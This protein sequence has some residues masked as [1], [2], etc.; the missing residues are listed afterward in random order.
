VRGEIAASADP[1]ERREEAAHD[2]P[3]DPGRH[4][5]SVGHPDRRAGASAHTANVSS[6]TF[7]LRM[8]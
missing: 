6:G 2:E 8:R 3:S 4:T 1:E 7:T 5:E